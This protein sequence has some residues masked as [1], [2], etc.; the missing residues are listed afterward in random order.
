MKLEDPFLE[1]IAKNIAKLA[2]TREYSLDTDS[3]AELVNEK[4]EHIC[5]IVYTRVE[6]LVNEMRDC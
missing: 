2:I 1:Q 6:E 3:C 5:N 4:L